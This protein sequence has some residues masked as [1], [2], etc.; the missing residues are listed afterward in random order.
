VKVTGIEQVGF[1]SCQ[2]LSPL[3][4]HGRFLRISATHII[5]QAVEPQ[6]QCIG[7][8]SVVLSIDNLFTNV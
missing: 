8:V 1:I 2:E 3:T 7:R 6:L 4:A 5:N